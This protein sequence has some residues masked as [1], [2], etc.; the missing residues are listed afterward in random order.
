MGF[1]LLPADQQ[2]TKL[3]WK[4]I[5]WSRECRPLWKKT[6]C[7]ILG[8]EPMELNSENALQSLTSGLLP[9]VCSAYVIC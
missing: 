1:Q 4:L 2:E 8:Q 3:P 9:E 5:I 7:F 6:C